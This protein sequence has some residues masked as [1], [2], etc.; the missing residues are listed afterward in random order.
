MRWDKQK[1]KESKEDF[2]EKDDDDDKMICKQE[3]IS[4]I[5]LV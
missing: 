5:K 4:I 3:E 1:E 2:C